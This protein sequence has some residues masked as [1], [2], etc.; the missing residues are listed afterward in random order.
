MVAIE[1]SQ[2]L[3]PDASTIN[4]AR[5]ST[6]AAVFPFVVTDEPGRYEEEEAFIMK[7]VLLFSSVSLRS[8]TRL[9]WFA[10]VPEAL[11]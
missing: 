7:D 10:Q 11:G 3:C 9:V 5:M 6:G 2:L 4:F 1:A 8:S